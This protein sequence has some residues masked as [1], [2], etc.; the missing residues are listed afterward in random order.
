MNDVALSD[1]F[2][3][4]KEKAAIAEIEQILKRQ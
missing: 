3:S 2:V 4:A 1:G